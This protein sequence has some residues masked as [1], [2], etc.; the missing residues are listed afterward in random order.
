LAVA[1]DVDV[2]VNVNQGGTWS[3]PVDS[4]G[5]GS[6]V[7][8]DTGSG[9]VGL[10]ANGLA[11]GGS[12]VC[13][14]LRVGTDGDA[15]HDLAD[16]NEAVIDDSFS[17]VQVTLGY[18][19]AGNLTDD[20]LYKYTYDAW[21]RLVKVQ[22]PGITCLSELGWRPIHAEPVQ[23]AGCPTSMHG[24]G[25]SHTISRMA[26]SSTSPTVTRSLTSS[27]RRTGRSNC[28]ETTSRQVSRS[29]GATIPR[30]TTPTQSVW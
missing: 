4:A 30:R 10:G 29:T 5:N 16:A 11:P 6:N 19:A 17:S 18:D 25:S 2:W 20:G 28:A 3:H 26:A 12:V 27:K 23:S 22:R 1:D 7:L 24:H 15:D 21:N 13:D 14:Y 9:G 8:G